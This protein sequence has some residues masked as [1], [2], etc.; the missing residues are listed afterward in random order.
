MCLTLTTYAIL[1]IVHRLAPS[2]YFK[3]SGRMYTLFTKWL[4]LIVMLI[5]LM[6]NFCCPQHFFKCLL[7]KYATSISSVLVRMSNA[8]LRYSIQLSESGAS[9]KDEQLQCQ[10]QGLLLCYSNY[11]S[12]SGELWK[13]SNYSAIKPFSPFSL[14]GN[15]KAQESMDSWCTEVLFSFAVMAYFILCRAFG[16]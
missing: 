2:L 6:A 5:V 9:V 3:S 4:E 1:L 16:S 12:A 13:I 8:V 14:T 11:I 15:V 10:Q 7:C